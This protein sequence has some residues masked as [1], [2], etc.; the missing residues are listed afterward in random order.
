[1]FFMR[2]TVPAHER[3][4]RTG[5]ALA[6][7]FCINALNFFDRVIGGALG[8]PIRRARAMS[9]FMLGLPIAS[10]GQAI[11][12]VALFAACRGVRRQPAPPHS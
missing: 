11:L 3:R 7:L 6:V 12:P 5:Y 4:S 10:G 8:E 1:M 2:R 9:L